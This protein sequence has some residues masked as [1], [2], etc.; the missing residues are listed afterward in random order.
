VTLLSLDCLTLT[1]TSPVELIRSAAAADFDLV[2][3]WVNPPAPYPRQ[4]LTPAGVSESAALIADTGVGVHHVEVFDLVSEAAVRAYRPALETGARLGA[5][6]AL[7]IHGSNPDRAEV[8]DALA[9]FVELAAG[10]GLGVNLEPIAMGQTRTLA[11]ARDLIRAAGVDAGIL[12]DTYHLMRSG[13]HPADVAAIEPGLIRYVQ[14]NDGPATIAPEEMLAEAAGERLYPGEGVFPL[15]ELLAA[16]P[17]N[18][19]W[20]I[21]T[22]SLRRARGGV[23]PQMQAQEAMAALRRLLEAVASRPA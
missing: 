12:Y 11:E 8:I 21:E 15:V 14:I 10:Y 3:L 13:G 2:S 1:D 6:A 22:P 16:A 23:T 19:P 7:V 4:V 17:T 9:A 18:I 20:A 5:K